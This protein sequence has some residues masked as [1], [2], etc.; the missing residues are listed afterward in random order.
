M[1]PPLLVRP[2]PFTKGAQ[3]VPKPVPKED[4]EGFPLG[5]ASWAA[6]V[7][8]SGVGVALMVL[9]V[10]NLPP[11]LLSRLGVAWWGGLFDGRV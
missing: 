6:T 2:L 7:C 11:P 8:G 10:F 4:E 9:L 3:S 1:G 5:L